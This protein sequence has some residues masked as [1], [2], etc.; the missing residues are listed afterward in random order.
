MLVSALVATLVGFGLLVVALVTGTLWLAIACI[1]VC[2][3]GALLLVADILGL[4][5][6]LARFT[7]RLPSRR[8]PAAALDDR[9]AALADDDP[10]TMI[11]TEMPRVVEEPVPDLSADRPDLPA[12]P[13][14]AVRH[15]PSADAQV[16]AAY[17][18]AHH[19]RHE[20]PDDEPVDTHA[21]VRR[22]TDPPSTMPWLTPSAP[23]R[24]TR[25]SGD[26]PE[27][28]AV[29]DPET[30]ADPAVPRHHRHAAD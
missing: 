4:G 7:P 23:R 30:D 22:D 8:A 18:A 15:A 12:P 27:A 17:A 16:A 5:P 1:V 3:L 25:H 21:H 19:G 11:T 29:V 28:A 20:S 9:S 24:H 14:E 6:V 26:D 10:D 2:V 13:V